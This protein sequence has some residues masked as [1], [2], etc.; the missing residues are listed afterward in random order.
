MAYGVSISSSTKI[1]FLLN[2]FFFISSEVVGYIPDYQLS[3]S[4]P[5]LFSEVSRSLFQIYVAKC[6]WESISTFT[7]SELIISSPQ[8]LFLPAT[9]VPCK[10]KS[11]ALPSLYMAPLFIYPHIYYLSRKLEQSFTS[12]CSIVNPLP[13]INF[14]LIS[15]SNLPTF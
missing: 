10:I 7:Y 1:L 13:S 4:N 15:L 6:C 8:L 9:L 14:N 2:T 3:P 12:T 11:F 5:D